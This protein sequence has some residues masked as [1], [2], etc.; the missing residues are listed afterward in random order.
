ML[1]V[2]KLLIALLLSYMTSQLLANYHLPAL[3]SI[4]IALLLAILFLSILRLI[5]FKQLNNIIKA[6]E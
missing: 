5:S 3:W 2:I 1:T 6:E 4:T